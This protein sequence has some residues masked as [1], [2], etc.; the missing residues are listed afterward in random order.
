[1]RL[2]DETT[3]HLDNPALSSVRVVAAVRR[4]SVAQ[5]RYDVLR[6]WDARLSERFACETGQARFWAGMA[7]D[8]ADTDPE[9]A[10]ELLDEARACLTIAADLTRKQAEATV[11]IDEARTVLDATQ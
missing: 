10:L 9:R 3:V 7:G 2:Q 5:A 1:M 6:E 8:M 11:L 4:I